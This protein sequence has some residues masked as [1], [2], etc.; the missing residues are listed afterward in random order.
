M[1]QFDQPVCEIPRKQR[2]A[3]RYVALAMTLLLSMP[4]WAQSRILRE[5]GAWVEETIGNLPS[6]RHMKIVADVGSVE[7]ETGGQAF[8]Y[9]IRKR[10]FAPT[11][12]EARRQFDMLRIQ[13]GREGDFTQLRL[14]LAGARQM[15]RVS[16]DI[17]LQLPRDLAVIKVDTAGGNIVVQN[18]SSRLELVTRG[19]GILV[20]DVANSVTARTMGGSIRIEN[21][22]GDVL[23]QNGGGPINIGNVRGRAEI[24]GAGSNIDVNSIGSGFIDTD[25]GCVSVNHSGGNLVVKTTGGSLT[26]G[27]IEGSLTAETGGGNIRLG[28]ARG[29]VTATTANGNIELWKLYRGARAQSSAGAITAEFLGGRDAFNDSYLRTA[30]GDVLVYLNNALPANVH[31]SSEMTSGRGIR[32]D[33]TELHIVTEGGSFGPK[34]MFAEGTLNGGG[35]QLKVLTTVGQI[36]FRRAK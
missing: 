28:S 12:A 1:A 21:V 27:A 18:T 15:A 14:A 17:I 19:G 10:S 6:G 30:T 31:A 16:A 5:G 13:P 32:S 26:L 8:R 36:E 35:H 33:F 23:A 22:G 29:L 9:I 2:G 25:G 4:L 34:A 3:A 24:H 20:H 7:V 11:Q